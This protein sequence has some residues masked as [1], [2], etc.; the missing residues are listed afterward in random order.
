ME[1]SQVAHFGRR[2]YPIRDRVPGRQVGINLSMGLSQ[3]VSQ[4]FPSFSPVFPLAASPVLNCL[5][6]ATYNPK[7]YVMIHRYVSLGAGWATG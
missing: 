2:S 1:Y 6:N 3:R 7:V 5:A 4:F